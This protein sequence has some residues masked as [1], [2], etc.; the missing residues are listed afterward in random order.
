MREAYFVRPSVRRLSLL[1][2]TTNIVTLSERELTPFSFACVACATTCNM[3]LVEC[4]HLLKGENPKG[5]FW[6]LTYGGHLNLM[7]DV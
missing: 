6:R 4:L 7:S 2:V 3:L 5:T 1:G